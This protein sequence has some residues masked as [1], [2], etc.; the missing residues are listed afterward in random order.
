M[1]S[2]LVS[3][4]SLVVAL[5]ALA[6]SLWLQSRADAIAMQALRQ[7]E[8]EIVHAAAP[9][10]AELIHDMTSTT[11]KPFNAASFHP[12]TIEELVVPLT[13]I[14]DDMMQVDV[15]NPQNPK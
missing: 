2:P 10:I 11:K 15:P 14:M 8:A 7:R 9:N 1:K 5:S 12:T 4:V 6:H 3:L 13:Q